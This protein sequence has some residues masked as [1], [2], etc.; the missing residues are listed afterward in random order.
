MSSLTSIP[1][2]FCAPVRWFGHFSCVLFCTF[3]TFL[4]H[5]CPQVQQFG[6]FCNFPAVTLFCAFACCA[7]ILSTGARLWPLFQFY[8]SFLQ[9]WNFRPLGLSNC[10]ACA[11][12]RMVDEIAKNHKFMT[13]SLRKN[14][15]SRAE[16]LLLFVC[17]PS[18]VVDAF[19]M[20]SG[21][22]SDASRSRFGPSLTG[23]FPKVAISPQEYSNRSQFLLTGTALEKSTTA[24]V[25]ENRVCFF[26]M[27]YAE[28]LLLFF[29]AP[30]LVVDGSCD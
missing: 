20:L 4:V 25:N 18:L 7:S 16:S 5:F 8:T 12:K 14:G 23:L 27:P 9:S 15:Q 22:V 17:A 19:R 13:L 6:H 11:Q 29:C 10:R 2:Y 26:R 21:C 3:A 28:S 30:I 1:T 24:P